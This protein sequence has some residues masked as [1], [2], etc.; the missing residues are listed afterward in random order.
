MSDS[1]QYSNRKLSD[2]AKKLETAGQFDQAAE[3]YKQSYDSYPS[4]FVTSHY[5][6][7]LRKLGKSAEAVKFGRQLS[8]Q[9][10]DDPYVHK[11]LSWAIYDVYLKKSERTGDNEVDDLEHEKQSN[12]NF[13]K[14]LAVANYILS[15]ASATE[16]IL[17]TRTIFAICNEAKQRGNWQVMYDFASQLDPERLLAEQKE[18]YG[19]K[20]MSDHQEWLCKVVKPLFELKRYEECIDFA[21]KGIEKYPREKL[22]PWWQACSKK[23]LGQVEEALRELEQI[24]ARFHKEW[25]IQ[26]DIADGYLQL[27]Q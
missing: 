6:K 18:L 22:F 10:Q 15:K 17:R 13:Q 5:I 23:A 1:M 20:K 12:P 25:Y 19:Q 16:D 14:M 9:L 24:D 11:E 7:C 8:R 4:S 2:E 3:L 21:H 27:Q 26:R